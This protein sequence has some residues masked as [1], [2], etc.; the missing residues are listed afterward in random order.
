MFPHRKSHKDRNNPFSEGH[1]TI[2]MTLVP[3]PH[4]IHSFPNKGNG[5]LSQLMAQSYP[6]LERCANGFIMED[7]VP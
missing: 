4:M 5:L 2:V 7:R 6:D 3:F 1:K